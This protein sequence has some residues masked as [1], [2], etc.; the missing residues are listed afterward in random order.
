[1][2]VVFYILYYFFAR[3][4]PASYSPYTF[5]AMCIRYWICKHLFLKCGK[6]V[7]I[8][9]GVDIGT[10]RHTEI[11]DNSGIGVHCVVNRAII[12]KNVMMGPD[13]VFIS[14]NHNFSDPNK[15]LQ[16]QGF[17]ESEPVVGDNTWVRTRAIIFAGCRIDKNEIIGVGSIVTKDVNDYAIVGG[18]P[19][20]I[21]RFRKD[22]RKNAEG[23]S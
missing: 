14:Q 20:R 17:T 16:E 6:N 11:G 10:G 9:H 4:L 5:G 2:R 3:H 19:V 7:N 22:P 13:V 21:I 18:N 23:V 8:E 15:P 1:M 12:G